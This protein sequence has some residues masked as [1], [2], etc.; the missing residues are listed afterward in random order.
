MQQV[1]DELRTTLYPDSEVPPPPVEVR[2]LLRHD[3]RG[4]DLLRA[5]APYLEQISRSRIMD[6]LHPGISWWVEEVDRGAEIG[7][8][9]VRPG[10]QSSSSSWASG[11]SSTCRLTG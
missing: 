10:A 1:P 8:P 11:S 3:P 7:A 6:D 9:A 4:L 5:E 2:D